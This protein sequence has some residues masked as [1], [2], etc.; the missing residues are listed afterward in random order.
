MDRKISLLMLVGAMFLL[1][2]C[3]P[4]EPQTDYPRIETG[5]YLTWLQMDLQQQYL[6]LYQFV[7]AEEQ[8]F[9]EKEIAPLINNM[10][11]RVHLYNQ[12]VLMDQP[13]EYTEAEIRLL[14]RQIIFKISE[15]TQ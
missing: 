6:E 3:M 1:C 10:K 15:V 4:K 8:A 2:A 11:H 7:S 13:P 14:A 9:M 5:I 12:A